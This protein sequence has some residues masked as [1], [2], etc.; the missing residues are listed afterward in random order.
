M[1]T[2]LP[3]RPAH[4]I[5]LDRILQSAVI[6]NW[7][8]LVQATAGGLL[9]IEYHIGASRSVDSLKMW[10]SNT[11]GYWSL[12]CDYSI[13]PGWS[14][15]PRFSNGFH[16]RD[17]GRLLESIMMNQDLF[18]HE[19]EPN[20]NVVVQVAPPTSEATAIAKLQLTEIFPP[21]APTF[22]KPAP[23]LRGE[24]PSVSGL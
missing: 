7:K 3:C 14:N 9:Q 22:R 12:I 18:R 20:R 8:D 23:R 21:P 5:R 15:G 17:L 16:S 2:A 1:T 24:A 19:S 13:H 4:D 6:L 11:R 10:C